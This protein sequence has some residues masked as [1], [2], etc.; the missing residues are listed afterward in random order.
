MRKHFKK[1]C[2]G[3]LGIRVE[4]N[5]GFLKQKFFINSVSVESAAQKRF[6][7]KNN[8]EYTIF[9]YFNEKYGITLRFNFF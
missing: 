8:R 1:L 6:K 3:V 7:D 5:Y 4:T 2:L 9:G